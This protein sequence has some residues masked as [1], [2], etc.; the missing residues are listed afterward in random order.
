MPFEID[1]SG[2]SQAAAVKVTPHDNC[3]VLDLGTGAFP[4]DI[5]VRLPDDDGAR[6]IALWDG[7]LN[8]A[9]N[10]EVL[11]H[12]YAGLSA[13][14]VLSMGGDESGAGKVR[15][16]EVWE[17]DFGAVALETNATGDVGIGT[18]G[19][20]AKL[21]ILDTGGAQLRLTFEDGV[22]FADF[23]LDTNHDLTIKPSSTGQVIFQPTTDSIDFFRVMDADGG[24]PVLNVDTTNERVSVGLAAPSAGFEVSKT[25]GT[26]NVMTITGSAGIFI[27]DQFGDFYRTGLNPTGGVRGTGAVGFRIDNTD[28]NDWRIES[29]RNAAAGSIEFNNLDA[30]TA[31]LRTKL[32]ILGTGEVGVGATAPA[33]KF[34]TYETIS[35]FIVWEFDG[36]DATVRTIIPN[37][38]GDVLYRL[39]AM[40][41]LRD[42][43]AAVAS[44]TADVSNAAS[45][46]LTVGS[47]TVRLRVNADGSCDVARTAGTD[48]IKV[49]LA[50]RWL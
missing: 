33:G 23:T 45:V 17:S 37:G 50:L 41:V 29:V 44:G 46:N 8:L 35:G 40:Y 26:N 39:T 48:T 14:R 11:C 43:A 1:V 7:S 9:I 25:S 10:D 30:P 13:W 31:P 32:V 27:V 6:Q 21:D 22:K 34:H 12:E 47:N 15:V 3:I 20:D 16:S 36:L 18:S 49:A 28:N 2:L 4:R 19:P 24:T 5:E 38:T 42:S